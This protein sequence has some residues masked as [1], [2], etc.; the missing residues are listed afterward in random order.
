[1]INNKR[2]GIILAGGMGTRL[3]PVTKV[4]NKHLI[5]I[6]DKPMIYYPLSILML[7]KIKDILLISDEFS[8]KNYKSLL[9]DGRK[10]GLNINYEIQKKPC[11]IAEAFIISKKFLNNSPSVLILGDNIFYGSNLINYFKTANKSKNSTIFTYKVSKPQDYG[12]LYQKG[13]KRTI[14]EK[15]KK[16][17]SNNAVV[18][19]YFYDSKATHYVNKLKKS[20]RNELE[21]TDLNNIYLKRRKTN[22]I[23][24]GRG[25]AWLDTG[26]FDGL[27]N[28]SNFIKTLQERQGFKI[29]DI[30]QIYKDSKKK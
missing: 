2:K 4:I 20:D 25:I 23:H 10:I 17:Y 16:Y 14:I 3:S 13:N 15:P 11:G 12:V 7:I 29:G 19:I 28:A 21:I 26:T 9:G 24:L 5:P 1:M 22:V 18:G 8:I 6:Y 27:L 30:N